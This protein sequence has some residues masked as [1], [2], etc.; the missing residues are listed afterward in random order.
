MTVSDSLSIT[1]D[2]PMQQVLAVLRDIDR[3]QDWFPGNTESQVLERDDDGLPTRA[4]MV[5]DVKIAKDEF[6]LDYTHTASGFAWEL[7]SPTRVQK[8]HRGS[9]ALVARGER[10][11]ATMSL[12]VDTSLPLPGFVQRRTVKDTLQGATRALAA[13]F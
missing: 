3:Q 2:A 12:T 5:N 9:W 6:V 4:R 1:V 10:T 11:E 8:V 13:Q 7:Q